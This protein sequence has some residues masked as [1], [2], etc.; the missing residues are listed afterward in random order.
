MRPIGIRRWP[1]TNVALVP[2]NVAKT[3]RGSSTKQC[4]GRDFALGPIAGG[5]GGVAAAADSPQPRLAPYERNLVNSLPRCKGG[6]EGIALAQPRGIHLLSAFR[7]RKTLVTR[8]AFHATGPA[9]RTVARMPTRVDAV[10]VGHTFLGILGA[11]SARRG[12][13]VPA[14]PS[15]IPPR[16]L[17][18]SSPRCRP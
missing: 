1:A 14:W 11:L 17:P 7:W 3:W 9:A 16:R 15:I 10:R 8:F 2:T 13:F 4:R 5:V 6:R 12:P 18:G